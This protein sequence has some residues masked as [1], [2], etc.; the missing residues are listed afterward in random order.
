M[1]ELHLI[2]FEDSFTLNIYSELK[3]LGLSP[4]LSSGLESKS[5]IDE[6]VNA[7]QKTAIIL[8]PGPGSPD[9][10]HEIIELLPK[11]ME[12]ENVFIMGIC[13][14]HQL[15]A[16]SL[17][18]EVNRSARPAH[19]EIEAYVLSE[20]LSKRLNFSEKLI[21]AQRYN[22]LSAKAD[23][24]AVK[25]LE[26]RGIECLTKEGESFAFHSERLLTYQFHPESVGTSFRSRFFLPVKN[27]LL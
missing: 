15:V 8:G 12:N 13:L 23:G 17:G 22:S 19:G 16:R 1:S 4:R 2:D 3:E 11:L 7:R 6:L 25:L 10:R 18:L 26:G 21:L 27:I 20:K 24:K 14:G 9:E 5:L